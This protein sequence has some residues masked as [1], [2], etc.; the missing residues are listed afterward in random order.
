MR[1][2]VCLGVVSLLADMTYEGARSI[3]GPLLKGLGANA[4]LVGIIAGLGE[5]CGFTLRLASGLL[6][7]RTRAYWSL[8][9]LG[10]AVNMAA[11]PLLAFAGSWQ[12]AAILVIAE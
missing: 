12:M 1:F 2:I 9:L 3:T 6:A 7:D 11:V 4:A 10:Y 8:T 5:L